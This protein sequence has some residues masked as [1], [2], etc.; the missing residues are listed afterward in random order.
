LAKRSFLMYKW[1]K[2]AVLCRWIEAC[3][4]GA[5]EEQMQLQSKL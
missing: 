2:S 4:G 1:L 3:D 5:Q